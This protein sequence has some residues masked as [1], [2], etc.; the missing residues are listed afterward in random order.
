MVHVDTIVHSLF[1]KCLL[2][3]YWVLG[4][5]LGTDYSLERTDSNPCPVELI[6]HLGTQ[7]MDEHKHI[8]V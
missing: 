2:S 5:L 6:F 3:T 4:A 8:E 1:N 7:S